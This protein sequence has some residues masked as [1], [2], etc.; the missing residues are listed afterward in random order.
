MMAGRNRLANFI[1]NEDTSMSVNVG[2]FVGYIGAGCLALLFLTVGILCVVVSLVSRNN[3]SS[4]PP[5]RGRALLIGGVVLTVI[6]LGIGFVDVAAFTLQ[7]IR[8]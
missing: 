1:I 6:G 7:I 3:G 5:S 4:T 2:Y 8:L